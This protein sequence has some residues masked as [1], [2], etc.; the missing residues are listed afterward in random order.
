MFFD[1]MS[2]AM[3]MVKGGKV[4]ALAITSKQRSPLM[5]EVPT[6]AELG[7]PGYEYHTWFGLWAP[8]NTPQPIVE[9]LHAEVVKALQNK[10]VRERIMAT[11][12]IPSDMPRAEMTPFVK[13]EITKW[14]AVV[15][16][17]GIK[18]K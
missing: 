17:A 16:R 15:K 6:V 14:A 1:N 2:A 13:A 12:G 11:A 18:P 9:K 5:P 4:R 8:K 3:N 10:T 7:V